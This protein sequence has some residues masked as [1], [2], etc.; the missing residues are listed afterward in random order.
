M[1]TFDAAALI[2]LLD[3]YPKEDH[4]EKG[5][6]YVWATS[7]Q[8]GTWRTMHT[9]VIP[10]DIYNIWNITALARDRRLSPEIVDIIIHMDDEKAY[11]YDPSGQ[12]GK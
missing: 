10:T 12:F 11:I 1:T 2:R 5:N 8:C 9:T 6:R 3:P 7:S 4:V